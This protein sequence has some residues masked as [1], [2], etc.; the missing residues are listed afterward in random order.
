M[1]TIA[2]TG[3][4]GTVGTALMPHIERGHEVIPI[5]LPEVDILDPLQLEKALSSADVVIHLAGIF[6]PASEGKESWRSPHS[7]P[8]NKALFD[9]V[10]EG[11]AA[12]GVG[13]L[14]HASSIHVEDTL[15]FMRRRSGEMLVAEAGRFATQTVSG[16]GKVKREQEAALKAQAQQFPRGAVSLRLGGVTPNNRPMT[17]HRDQE[18]LWH[19]QSVW[20][21]HG[22]LASLVLKIV[23]EPSTP[24]DYR[25][26]YAVS[27]NNGRF[28]DLANP[29]GWSPHANSA[30]Y[31]PRTA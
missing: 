14:L 11:S 13:L 5:D 22:D 4:K 23:A 7:D 10:L 6:G 24:E 29:Y 31:I 21:S 26:L 25:V 9:A 8:R 16:Y 19:E 30:N 2:V 20:L 3:A 1:S 28:H 12:V 17:E 15:G 27:N 18:V